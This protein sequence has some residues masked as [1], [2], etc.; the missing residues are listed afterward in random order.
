M[1]AFATSKVLKVRLPEE[2]SDGELIRLH[3]SE[4]V[5]EL[6]DFRFLVRISGKKPIVY[7]RVLGHE[8]AVTLGNRAHDQTVMN[9]RHL[10]G[11]VARI[12]ELDRDRNHEYRNLELRV[13]PQAWC[14][15][16]SV[17]RRIFQEKT[18]LQILEEVLA[19]TKFEFRLRRRYFAHSYCVQYGESDFDFASR[20]ME[21]DGIFYFFEHGADGHQMV[22]TDAIEAAKSIPGSDA[23]RYRPDIEGGGYR[24]WIEHWAKQQELR[25]TRFAVNDYSFELPTHSLR[26]EHRAEGTLKAGSHQHQLGLADKFPGQNGAVVEEFPSRL[27]QRFDSVRRNGD[28]HAADPAQVFELNRQQARDRAEA[29]VADSF[30]IDAESNCGCVIPGHRFRLSGHEHADG[31]YFITR[32]EH[33]VE[34][35]DA[36]IPSTAAPKEY[37]NRFRCLPVDWMYRPPHRT[38]RPR[39]HGTETAVVIGPVGEEISTD[40]YGRVRVAFPWDLRDDG[41]RGGCWIRVAQPWSGKNYGYYALPRVGSEVVVD[42]IDGDPDRPIIVGSVYNADQMPPFAFPAERMVT[43]LKSRTYHGDNSDFHGLCFDDTSGDELIQMRSQKDVLLEAKNSVRVEA[44]N[45]LSSISH[46]YH[47]QVAGGLAMSGGSGS[48][49]GGD[50][51]FA[52]HTSLVTADGSGAGGDSGDGPQVNFKSWVRVPNVPVGNPFVESIM[53]TLGVSNIITTG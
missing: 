18:A 38:P 44:P 27:A 6:F 35:A 1:S 36:R 28:V 13:V 21:E 31:D 14:L 4:A 25:S 5:S 39:A 19:G 23:L 10:H 12:A 49:G 41:Q 8:V 29:A 9:Q 51:D 33:E 32:V 24:E 42:Y 30:W 48:G 37:A 7:D 2:I 11:I 50:S 52:T 45:G 43:G 26:C 40:K 20:L 47:L 3:G 16:Q 17:R 46:G 34:V 22:I 15:T 53:A